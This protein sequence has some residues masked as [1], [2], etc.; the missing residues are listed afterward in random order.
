VCVGLVFFAAAP[1]CA[2]TIVLKNGRRITAL[3][4]TERGEKIE[5]ET[6]SGTLTL[7]KSIVDHIERGGGQ[8]AYAEAAANLAITAPALESLGLASA[9]SAIEQGAVHDGIIDRDYIAKLESG[10]RAGGR[11]EKDSAALAHH[12]AA[13]FE[14]SQGDMDHALT[15]EHAALSYAPERWAL[16]LN[17]AYL[18]LKR[19][20][21]RQSA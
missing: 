18:H 7:P 4:V 3:S 9:G 5:Y 11:A 13:Q 17:V 15:D 21:F 19:S 8:G 1:A 14:M 10:A 20:E 2:D 16:L 6:A 12:V